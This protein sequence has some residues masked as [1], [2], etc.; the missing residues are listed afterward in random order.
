MCRVC[1]LF[2]LHKNAHIL[3]LYTENPKYICSHIFYN[4]QFVFM[5]LD[6]RK[7]S[8]NIIYQQQNQA[9]NDLKGEI[10]SMDGLP[11]TSLTQPVQKTK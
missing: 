5:F 1:K 2:Y 9:P 8:Q 6:E 3:H 7:M 4:N 11:Y 10:P